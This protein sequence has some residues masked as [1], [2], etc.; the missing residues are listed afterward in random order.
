MGF[1]DNQISKPETSKFSLISHVLNI[2]RKEWPR[3][4]VSWLIT[5]FFRVGFVVGWTTLTGMFV[6]RFGIEKLPLLFLV[7]GF[8][9]IL[10][11]LFYSDIVEKVKREW[12]IIITTITAAIFL[13]IATFFAL[14]SNVLFFTFLL[15]AESILLTQLNILIS[16]YREEMFSPLESERTFPIIESSET[17]GSIFA[18]LIITFG[19]DMI[20]VHKFIFVWIIALTLIVPI[21]FYSNSALPKLPVFSPKRNRKQLIGETNIVQRLKK[22]VYHVQTIPFLKGLFLVVLLQW[23]FINILEFQ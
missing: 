11:T 23:I 4:R 22:S 2:N 19:S 9:I 21:I 15:F 8:F 12:L 1:A 10:G 14:S 17:I 6:A 18:G 13:F 3:V 5:F 7:N 20:A 16:L